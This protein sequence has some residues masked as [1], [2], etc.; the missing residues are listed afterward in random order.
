MASPSKPALDPRNRV[1]SRAYLLSGIFLVGFLLIFIQHAFFL[2]LK[3][4]L[5]ASAQNERVR[6]SIGEHLIQDIREI[7]A[8]F[9]RMATLLEPHA[10]RAQQES[11]L[12]TVKKI[13]SLLLVIDKGGSVEF[14]HPL[15]LPGHDEIAKEFTYQ[16]APGNK[17]NLPV[18]ELRPLLL[19]VTE[20]VHTLAEMLEM[21]S[22]SAADAETNRQVIQQIKS[23]LKTSAPLFLRMTEN[24]NKLYYEGSQALIDLEQENARRK[25]HYLVLEF[26]SSTLIALIVLWLSYLVIRDISAINRR[27]QLRISA[28]EQS[29]RELLASN[30][31][32]S[33]LVNSIDALIYVADL[34]T[35]E[36]LF[37]NQKVYDL[38][39]ARDERTCWAYFHNLQGPC[40]FCINDKLLENN[41]GD[42]TFIWEYY[43]EILGRWLESR[44]RIIEWDLG[45]SAK[46]VIAAD[47]TDR[48]NAEEE[49]ERMKAQL[50]QSHKMEAIGTLAGGIAHDFNNILS[51][52]FGYAQLAQRSIERQQVERTRGHIEK[53]IRV[54]ERAAKLVEQILTFSRQSEVTR[55]PLNISPLLKET[56]KL[57]R[58]TLPSNI[59]IRQ[60]LRSD[61]TILANSTQIHQV[62]MNLCTNAYHAMGENGGV[63]TIA[64]EEAEIRDQQFFPEQQIFPGRY[65][66]LSVGDTGKGIRLEDQKKIFD[67]FFTTKEQGKGTGLG[68]SVVDGIIKK[69]GGAITLDS[70]PG[71]GTTFTIYLPII[72][73]MPSSIEVR[74]EQA[75]LPGG[76]EAIMLIDDEITI[77]D[78]LGE[79]LAE[80]GYRVTSFGDGDSALQAFT[81]APQAY[82]LVIT[83]MT[84]PHLTGDKLSREL[85]RI[86]PD[87]PIIICTGYHDSFGEMDARELGISRFM[88]KPTIASDLL[89]AVRELLDRSATT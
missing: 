7:E 72:D 23:F 89:L 14:R 41:G 2:H 85:L 37:A 45:R 63:L 25:T 68:L 47:I 66:K 6:I 61:A 28:H 35:H 73:R 52:I 26:G 70:T 57:L 20:R 86:R 40:D 84:M 65:L 55:Q 27:L 87:L 46:L 64:L 69:H 39:G 33:H 29:K 11:I 79:I 44:E 43:N 58:S 74:T 38:F 75:E 3:G 1:L 9:Y 60:D 56:L 24:A 32:F 78:T 16:P 10:Q 19:D 48:K 77:I 31:R 59:E 88:A 17:Y 51:G 22:A 53:L 8:N 21:R 12:D 13:K 4:Q 5:E 30:K 15:N 62:I 67:P 82:D 34:D 49:K 71:Q 50:E 18:I 54:T 80:R 83:D 76:H 42:A 81:E 36:I